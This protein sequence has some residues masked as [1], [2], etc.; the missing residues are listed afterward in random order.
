[1]LAQFYVVRMPPLGNIELN[2]ANE[3]AE[4]LPVIT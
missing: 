4:H 3:S 2:Q 1:M